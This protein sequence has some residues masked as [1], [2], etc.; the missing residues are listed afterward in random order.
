MLRAERRRRSDLVVAA[1]IV[2]VVAIGA[3][4]FAVLG[5][6]AKTTLVTADG[7][8]P[9]APPAAVDVPATLTELWRAPSPATTTPVAEGTA[10]V[11]G[12][13]AA[14]GGTVLGREPMT[15][16]VRWSYHRD[17][18]LCL[19][20][21]GWHAPISV[22]RQ[23]VYCSDV[24]KFD[25]ATGKRERQRN[26]DINPDIRFFEVGK[27]LGASSTDYLEVW[28]VDLIK[29]LMYGVPRTDAQPR[30][31]PHRGCKHIGTTG[32]EGRVVVLER[33]PEEK[34]DRLTAIRPDGEHADRPEVEFSVLLPATGAKLV[35]AASDRVAVMLP[36]PNRLSIRDGKGDEVAS[37]PLDLPR[38]DLA[39]DQQGN[40]AP[41][42]DSLRWVLWWTGS[43]TLGLDI[44]ELRPVWA[45]R[46]TLGPGTSWSGRLV[47]PVPNGLAV[48][49]A[50]TG[51]PMRTIPV[52]RGGWTGPVSLHTVG[53]VL[54]E[55]RGP[56]VVALH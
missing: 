28:R 6:G 7:P 18:P 22:F 9:A 52:N 33:C 43:R 56:T 20:G 8:I 29:T 26:A 4:L 41:T 34:T 50:D 54:L 45:E 36:N 10:V 23:G 5:P 14:D 1:A 47:I 15:G 11:T 27:H 46:N 21:S 49:N 25:P 32:T 2:V 53:S 51:A 55:Q 37:F 38:T 42:S 39:G 31:Q 24:T 40:L 12:D 30:K 17:L 3:V 48:L 13:N 35:S 19:V 44:A 16:R